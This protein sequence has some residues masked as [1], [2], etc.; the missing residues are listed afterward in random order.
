MIVKT[1]LEKLAKRLNELQRRGEGKQPGS[2]NDSLSRE[3]T[4]VRDRG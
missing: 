1:E 2:P 3:E 4:A